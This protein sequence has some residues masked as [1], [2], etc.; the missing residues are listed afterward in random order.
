MFKKILKLCC[1]V[2]VLWGMLLIAAS[3]LAGPYDKLKNKG[4]QFIDNYG[5][6]KPK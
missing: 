3:T 4:A 5:W 6:E 1:F 2:G